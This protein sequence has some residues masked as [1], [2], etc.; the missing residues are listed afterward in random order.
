MNIYRS[1]LLLVSLCVLLLVACQPN[2]STPTTS[3]KAVLDS[4]AIETT[5]H[6][7]FEEKIS[8]TAIDTHKFV[9]II[10]STFYTAPTVLLAKLDSLYD[11]SYT[12]KTKLLNKQQ[13]QIQGQEQAVYLLQVAASTVTANCDNTPTIDYFL[14]DYKGQLLLQKQ[15]KEVAL[16]PMLKDS[17]ALL[18]T[19]EVNCEQMGS[20]RLYAYQNGE[21]IDVLNTLLDEAPITYDGNPAGGGKFQKDKLR[22][23]VV[24]LNED[25]H[26]DW[27]LEGKWLV[28]ENETGR[29]YKPSYPYKIEPI[30]QAYIYIP[31]KELFLKNS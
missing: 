6:T 15:A 16:L 11:Y 2:N 27:L 1:W 12:A 23:S 28:L 26:N 10:D 24:D 3:T 21:M 17:V 4:S 25:G 8:K 9:W 30:R 13:Y 22:W 19:L 5:D 29:T 14:F 31:A 18:M 7:I 20:Y